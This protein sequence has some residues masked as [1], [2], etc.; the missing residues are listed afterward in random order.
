MEMGWT[1]WCD[2]TS[3]KGGTCCSFD[4]VSGSK[5]RAAEEF[6]KSGWERKKGKWRCPACV[7]ENRPC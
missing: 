6:I 3:V 5:K 7:A 1:V 4:Q 2:A